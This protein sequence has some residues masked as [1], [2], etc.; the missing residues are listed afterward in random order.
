[1]STSTLRRWHTTRCKHLAHDVAAPPSSTI[2]LQN[3]SNKV[4]TLFLI[5]EWACHKLLRY[6]IIVICLRP[7]SEGERMACGVCVAALV[8]VLHMV[9]GQGEGVGP[10]TSSRGDWGQRIASVDPTLD[11]HLHL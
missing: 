11:L 8:I 6:L 1:M 10:I 5:F 2:R 3:F 7:R 9:H 4:L